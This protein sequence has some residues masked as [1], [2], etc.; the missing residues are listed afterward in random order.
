MSNQASNA[1]AEKQSFKQ[2]FTSRKIQRRLVIFSFL[3]VPFLL[4]LIFT[5][6]PFIKM[7]QFSF[8]NMKYLGARTFV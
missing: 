4:L 5:Y 7:V 1:Q 8:Y 2:W 6:V 3:L